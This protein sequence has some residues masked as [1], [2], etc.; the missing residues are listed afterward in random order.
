[1]INLLIHAVMS[2][3]IA[4]AVCICFEAYMRRRSEDHLCETVINEPVSR[5][6]RCGELYRADGSTGP[7]QLCRL[8]HGH[9][10]NHQERVRRV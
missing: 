3:A 6:E 8:E 7:W 5:L 2:T 9:E 4:L 10:G 1:M